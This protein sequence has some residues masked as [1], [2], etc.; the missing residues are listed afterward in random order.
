MDK[1]AQV[2]TP[3]NRNFED[4]P[5]DEDLVPIGDYDTNTGIETRPPPPAPEDAGSVPLA[6]DDQDDQGLEVAPTSPPGPEQPAEEQEPEEPNPELSMEDV[7]EPEGPLDKVNKG[8]IRT[9]IF[10][11]M[12]HN[13]Q[14]RIVYTTLAGTKTE[15][16][17]EPDYVY[18][19]GTHR[20]VL[21]AWDHLRSDWRAFVV[22]RI[23]DPSKK[24]QGVAIEEQGAQ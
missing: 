17:V 16:T 22:D 10:Y 21:I 15:R 12:T 1:T 7:E 2:W 20:H 13:L 11:A 9:K 14:L 5:N 18:W 6:D 23:G 24:Y 4:L 3:D 8:D 19:A